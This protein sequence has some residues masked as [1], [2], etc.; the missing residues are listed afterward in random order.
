MNKGFS[1]IEVLIAIAIFSLS[2]TAVTLV[3]FSGQN[4]TSKALESRR[5]VELAHD[6]IE[7]LRFI[8][9]ANWQNLTDSPTHGLN[10]TSGVWT[11]T[12]S[13][14]WTQ[15]YK[16]TVSISTDFDGIKHARLTVAWS[17]PPEGTKSIEL[18]QTLGPLDQGIY[19]DWS[20]PCLLSTGVGSSGSSK[21]TDIVYSNSRVYIT[22]YE[23]SSGK[24]DLTIFNV[25]NP[26]APAFLSE[27]NT[28]AGLKSLAVSGNY[29]YA[30]EQDVANLK[31]IDISNALAPNVVATLNIG[32][33]KGKYIVINKNYAYVTTSNNPNPGAH[34]LHVINITTPTAPVK[35][36]GVDLG[37]PGG[38]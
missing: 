14:D 2:M 4:F 6:G 27:L 36:N 23:S 22:S 32:P 9:D 11:L 7:G 3:F 26:S 10:F 35:V 25:T 15:N 16:R 24:P 31:V 19:G 1:L 20:Q 12:G 37:F 38:V 34:E 8:R 28:G 5:A 33:T 29:A 30:I 13:P 21:G 17:S 18:Y